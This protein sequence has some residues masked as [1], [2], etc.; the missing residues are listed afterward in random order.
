MQDKHY[1]AFATGL[2][3]LGSMLFLI[4]SNLGAN[5][6]ARPAAAPRAGRNSF[7]A[8]QRPRRHTQRAATV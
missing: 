3:L 1:L 4:D 5:M 6:L 8:S 7:P 2:E